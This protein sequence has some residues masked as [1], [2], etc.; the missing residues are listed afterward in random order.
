MTPSPTLV[1][2]T[3]PWHLRHPRWNVVTVREALEALDP[4][5][6]ATTALPPGFADDP[7]WRATPEAALPWTVAPWA[8]R[9]GT[10]LVGVGAPPPVEGAEADLDRY[11]QGF[12]DA[13]AA[14]DG[15]RAVLEPLRERLPRPLDLAGLLA[16][17]VPLLADDLRRRL[18][19]F[20]DGPATAW[21]AERAAS[22]VARLRDL[23]GVRPALLVDLDLWPA[24]VT[25]LDA[26]GVP[27][28]T[29]AAPPVSAAAR[30]RALLDVA[31]HGEAPD[32]AGLLAQLREGDEPE[33]RFL[34]AQLLLAH[35]HPAEALEVLEQASHGDFRQP[36]LLPGLLLARLGQLRDLAGK[37]ERA[38]QAYRGALALAWAP[39]EARAAATAGLAAPFGGSEP[40]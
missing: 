24:L 27:W 6:I 32:V 25:A 40:G 15:A 23:G 22:A 36:Y 31:W 38:L 8:A 3:G 33:A 5:L 18:E 14:L 10:P 12:P 1:P 4:D 21:R 35:D 13:R 37:R 9:R 17:V 2:L 7:D 28:T 16:E 39:E 30:R 26:A 19:A 20:G 11:L 29:V 34:E